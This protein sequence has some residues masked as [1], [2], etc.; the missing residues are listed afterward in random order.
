MGTFPRKRHVISAALGA[1]I[2]ASTAV[3][4]AQEW[5]SG[6]ALNR[7]Q[8]SFAGDR[9]FG[10]PSPFVAGK[11][12]PHAM[13]LGEYAHNPLVLERGKEVVGAVVRSQ[14]FLHLNAGVALW[15]RV[16]LNLDVPIAV[17]QRGDPLT[18]GGA[19]I[20]TPSSA[21]MSDLR[22]G[23]RVSLYGQYAD[24]FQIAASGYLWFPT[25]NAEVGSYVSDGSLRGLPQLI[26]GGLINDRIVWS[27]AGGAEI[28]SETRTVFNVTQG[29]SFQGGLGL[30]YL[31]G[32]GKNVQ[33]GIEGSVGVGLEDPAIGNTNAE[34]LASGRVRVG[35]VIEI[36]LG[37]GPGIAPGEGTPS[38]RGVA[39]LA[40]TP[41]QEGRKPSP[42]D[43]DK[44]GVP[45]A[46]DACPGAPGIAS[47]DPKKNGCPPP[48]PPPEPAK[49]GT[50]EVE[51]PCLKEPGST[52]G[53]A[54]KGCPP[55]PDTD[56]DGIVDA[57]D[58]CVG[59]LGVADPD[60]KKNG[61]PADKDGDGMLDAEDACVDVPGLKTNDPATNGCPG[62]TDGDS[63]RDDKDAC[64][65]QKGKP[66]PDR[67][68]NGCPTAVATQEEIIISE[69]I[70][71][72]TGWATIKPVSDPL[73]DQIADV[74][75]QHPGIAKIEVQGHTD[76]TGGAEFNLKL[77]DDRAKAVVKALIRRGIAP[78]RL[79]SRGYGLSVPLGDNATEEGRAMNRR[80]QFKIIAKA[81][82]E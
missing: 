81:K 44:D 22:A 51:D 18:D 53:D 2:A 56:K 35:N 57:E 4:G 72:D 76:D 8:P 30:A 37:L 36:G 40:F 3:A 34:I 77:S 66:N 74:L 49:V 32:E 82:Q 60:P 17:Y 11:L 31:A 54:K 78:G 9:M 75:K 19:A 27:V 41:R 55:P 25:G 47:D 10:V 58:A 46:V 5:P 68:Y 28:R 64:P 61:C 42:P 80:V 39:M 71:F 79:T 20:P 24:P 38:F 67:R 50:P 43:R 52:N 1:A 65:T 73:L 29:S 59:V 16:G 45:D 23:L 13:V 63:I 62:D 14:L 12:T 26:L 6:F 21:Q 33:V 15:N 48:P 70:Q 69:Q 7:F